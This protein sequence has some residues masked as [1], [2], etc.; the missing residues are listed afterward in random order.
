MAKKPSSKTMLSHPKDKALESYKAWIKEFA[1]SLN[2]D[3]KDTMTDEQWV[4]GWKR[5]WSK[6]TTL[7]DQTEV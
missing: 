2:P 4:A 3:A 1:L 6:Y 5:F 7:S